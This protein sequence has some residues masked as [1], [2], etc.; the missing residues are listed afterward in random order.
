M[1]SQKSCE[2]IFDKVSI[3]DSYFQR[4]YLEASNNSYFFN[5]VSE[6]EVWPS[7]WV[8]HLS[9]CYGDELPKSFDLGELSEL[10]P[11][12]INFDTLSLYRTG[13]KVSEWL[14]INT[15]P[16]H[17]YQCIQKVLGF[18]PGLIS[19]TKYKKPGGARLNKTIRKGTYLC[20]D[21]H[22]QLFNLYIVLNLDSLNEKNKY[23][24]V[25]ILLTNHL[26][27]INKPSLYLVLTS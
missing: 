25:N 13:S 8:P 14:E 6:I 15:L 9:L 22:I 20:R 1:L 12:T 19:V 5:S 3:G 4:L 23:K 11:I 17:Q 27:N 16:L 10:I 24:N 7:L 26:Q 2:I 21:H 18:G